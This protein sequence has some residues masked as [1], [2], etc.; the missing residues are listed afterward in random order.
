MVPRQRH[1]MG[2]RRKNQREKKSALNFFVLCD[3]VKE[4]ERERERRRWRTDGG[5]VVLFVY[6]LCFQVVTKEEGKRRQELN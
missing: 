4:R 1:T 6:L 5:C 2:T 3:I